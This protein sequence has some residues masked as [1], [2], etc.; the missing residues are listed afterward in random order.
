MTKY[1]FVAG[2]VMSGIGKG[3]VTGSI[4]K[5]LQSKGYTSTALKID[6]YLNVDA[7]TMN[8]IEHGE[9]FVTDDGAEGDQDLGNYERFSGVNL[10]KDNYITTGKVYKA[11]IEKERNLGYEGKCVE[12]VPDIP[13]EVIRRIKKAAQ[14]FD[15]AVIEIGGTVGEYQ[16]LLFLEAA[17]MMHLENT[18][19]VLFILV[20]YLPVPNTIG[21]MKTK[22]TQTA[23]RTLNE[24]GIQ[25]DIIVGRSPVPMDEMR[26]KKISVFCNIEKED[27][28]SSPDIEC[29]YEAPLILEKEKIGERILEKVGLAKKKDE[30]KEWED[31]VKKI[32]SVKKSVKIAIIGKYFET[33]DFVLSDAY[34]SVIE[35]VKHA[36]WHLGYKEEISWIPSS[37]YEEDPSQLKE[38]LRYDG[39]IVPGGFGKR[40]VEGKIEAIRFC[41]ENKIPFFGLCLGMQLAVIE[42]A[43]NVCGMKEASSVEFN[44]NTPYPVIDIM[45]EQKEL[46]KNKNYGGTMRL[47]SYQCNIKKGT[48]AYNAYKKKDITERHRHR[49]EVNNDFRKKLEEKK[50]IVAGVNPDH[51]L[52][53]IIEIGEHPFFLGTQ[54]HPEYKSRPLSPHPLFLKFIRKSVH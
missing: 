31:L 1:I 54:F 51:D 42:F 7:G 12:V 13:N 11:V 27:V 38:L 15:F 35:A 9:V 49:F 23:S 26:K 16:N 33:G 52:V 6:P 30:M 5:I 18:K 14:G 46:M 19:D 50:M 34:I 8:P 36:C 28:I 10:S 53:E 45:L 37:R 2:G 22:P 47:G 17:R 4:L 40:G 29:I 43:R 25:P 24:A 20:S 39:V 48:T 32:K 21:E 44:K 41:R 3:V